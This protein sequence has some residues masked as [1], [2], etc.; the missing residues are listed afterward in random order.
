[1]KHHNTKKAAY[2]YNF[3]QPL[4]AAKLYKECNC[5]YEA[6]LSYMNAYQFLQAIECFYKTSDPLQRLAGLKQVEEVAIVLYLDK[7][8]EDSLKLF[9]ALG[10]YYSVL[11]CA[12]RCKDTSLVQKLQEFIATY[13]A[14]ENNYLTAAHYIASSNANQA[15]L[16]Y[17]LAETSND[18]LKLAIDKGNYF[19]ALKICFNTNNLPLAKQVAKLYA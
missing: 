4:Y 15:R 17:Y 6:G 18:A 10:D 3:T 14:H 11:E 16:Y 1:M 9:E 13:E 5:Y 7:Q 8:Y 2:F 12:K 19:T